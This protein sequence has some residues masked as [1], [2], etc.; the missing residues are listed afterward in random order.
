LSLDASTSCL[1][2]VGMVVVGVRRGGTAQVGSLF[3]HL[4]GGLAHK[5]G[6][7]LKHVTAIAAEVVAPM[8]GIPPGVAGGLVELLMH[9][10]A[11]D[12]KARAEVESKARDPKMKAAMSVISAHLRKHPDFQALRAHAHAAHG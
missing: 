4:F 11:G 9:A 1:H 6:A 10:H 2:H 8:F 3:S 5:F 7:M 12:K